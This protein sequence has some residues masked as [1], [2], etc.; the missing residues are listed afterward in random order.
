MLP[1]SPSG[2]GA[3]A[4]F[5]AALRFG[6]EMSTKSGGMMPFQLGKVEGPPPSLHAEQKRS[7]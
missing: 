4:R 5:L 1:P 6:S 7:D 2:G 3:G